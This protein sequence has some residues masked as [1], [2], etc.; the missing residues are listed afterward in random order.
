LTE[1]AMKH[2]ALA[3]SCSSSAFAAIAGSATVTRGRSTTSVKWPPSSVVS[4][5]TPYGSSA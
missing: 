5:M 2:L 3:A 4:A 1:L